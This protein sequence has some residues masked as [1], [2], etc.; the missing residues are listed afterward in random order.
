MIFIKPSRQSNIIT[1]TENVQGGL[2]DKKFAC[3]VFID[4]EE[5]FDTVNHN[6]LLSK[7]NYLKKKRVTA[8]DWFKS[9]LSKQS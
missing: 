5:E 2:D 6:I 9:Y 8:N 4:T 1:L 7:D 3:G